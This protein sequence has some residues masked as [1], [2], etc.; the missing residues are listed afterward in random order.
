MGLFTPPPPPA[1]KTDLAAQRPDRATDLRTRLDAW[2][3]ETDANMPRP[4][5]APREQL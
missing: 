5:I 1:E 2:R 3:K 4:K